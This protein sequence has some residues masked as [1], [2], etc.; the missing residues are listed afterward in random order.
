M[1]GVE[2]EYHLLGIIFLLRYAAGK[3]SGEVSLFNYS[4]HIQSTCSLA[5]HF[6]PLPLRTS[7][8]L[9]DNIPELVSEAE[10]LV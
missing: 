8:S 9:S 10:A 3:I 6:L 1:L 2:S 4:I 5:L 7:I